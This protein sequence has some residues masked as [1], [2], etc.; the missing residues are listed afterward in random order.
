MRSLYQNLAS[1]HLAGEVQVSGF[2][3][4]VDMSQ[5]DWLNGHVHRPFLVTGGLPT[6]HLHTI[7]KYELPSRRK[8]L[9]DVCF[10]ETDNPK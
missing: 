8:D 1:G 7:V 4:T 3:I 6:A 9:K 2:D 10:P 5:F